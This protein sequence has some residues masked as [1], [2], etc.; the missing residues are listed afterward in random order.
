[1]IV[2]NA[3][4]KILLNLHSFLPN[5]EEFKNVSSDYKQ[6]IIKYERILCNLLEQKMLENEQTRLYLEEKRTKHE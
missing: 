4:L 3:Q 1:M 2:T 6:V 5:D